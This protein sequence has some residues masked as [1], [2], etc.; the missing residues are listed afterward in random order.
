MSR[1]TAISDYDYDAECGN[2]E[3]EE[4]EAMDLPTLA[5][6]QAHRRAPQKGVPHQIVKEEKKAAKA[7]NED[8]FRKAVWKRDEGKCRA[9]GKP[10]AKSGTTDWDKLG[11]VDHSVPRSL[12]PERIFDVSNGLLLS[13]RLN[14]LRKAVCVEQPEYR[15]FDYTGPDDRSLPQHFT[16]RDPRT[17]KITKQRIG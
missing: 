7:Q 17:G 12:A 10:L 5:E 3:P 4:D 16:W 2:L 1:W 9:T 15:V 11:E 13:K 6:M 8:T 14:R